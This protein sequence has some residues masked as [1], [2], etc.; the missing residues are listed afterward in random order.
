MTPVLVAI[1]L[2]FRSVPLVTLVMEQARRA[3][4]DPMLTVA[5]VEAESRFDPAAL[6]DDGTSWGLFQLSSRWHPQERESV[7]WHA[8]YGSQY[9]SWCIAQEKGSWSAALERYNSGRGYDSGRVY[10][11][12]VLGIYRD[13]T[14][15]GGMFE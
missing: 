12:R 6:G 5:L 2:G 15:R 14:M 4:V 11:E 7:F 8:A 3:G 1:L 13:I 10:S 9:I